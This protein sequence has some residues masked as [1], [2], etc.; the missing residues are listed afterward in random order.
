MASRHKLGGAIIAN[1]WKPPLPQT[2]LKATE[3]NRTVHKHSNWT[4]L[5]GGGGAG[6]YFVL[7]CGICPDIFG[8][9]CPILALPL[10]W[11]ITSF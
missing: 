6:R 10:N 5:P 4:T 7:S 9:D 2:M 1:F 11:Q 3:I 8:Q